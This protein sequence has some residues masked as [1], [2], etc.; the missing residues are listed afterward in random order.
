MSFLFKLVCALAVTTLPLLAQQFV[1]QGSLPGPIVWSEAVEVIDANG[2]GQL[3]VI[4][5]NGQGFSSAQGSRAPTLLINQGG[6][7][8]SIVFA[9]ETSSRIPAGFV[10]QGKGLAI[11]DVNGDGAPDVVFAN[12]FVTQPRVLVNDGTGNFADETTT[13]FPSV[14]LGAFGVA[15]IDADNDGDIDLVFTDG[16]SYFLASPGRPP[17]LFINDG[18]GVFTDS[19]AR[20]NGV[21]KIG[22]MQASAID[23]DNDL[24]LDVIIDGRS[25]G[26]HLY[27]NDGTGTFTFAGAS[28]LPVGGGCIYETDWADLDNDGDADGFYISMSGFSEGTAR[29]NLGPG[30]TGPTLTFTGTTNTISGVNGNDD[31]EAA[32]IDANNDGFLDVLVA[33]LSGSREKLYLNQ[34]TFANGSFVYQSS[35]F[36]TLTDSTLDLAIGDFDQDGRYDVVTAQGESGNYTNRLY[37]NT[38]PAD[39]RAPT[40]VRVEGLPPMLGVAELAAGSR[41][42]Q[43]VDGTADSGRTLVSVEANV[44]ITRDGQTASVILPVAYSGGYLWRFSAPAGLNASQFV[45]AD[46]TM[47]FVAADPPGNIASTAPS[48]TR[49]C[50]VNPYGVA[51]ATNNMSISVGAPPTVGQTTTLMSTGGPANQPAFVVSGPSRASLPIAGGVVLVDPA[52]WT[53]TPLTSDATGTVSFPITVPNNP[54][55]AGAFA[56]YQVAVVDPSQPMGW[57]A[58]TGLE[59]AT[60]PF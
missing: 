42:M 57:S 60:C 1:Y 5:T 41:R 8:G 18:T 52:T 20:M 2:D 13:R 6:A 49:I 51:S 35:G 53:V 37:R 33:S 26:Q 54:A 14:G 39:S 31:N 9:D 50:G 10:Q 19:P 55:N 34:G 25:P 40:F 44:S 46:I 28:V 36:T 11:C 4:F 29:N 32:F 47:V 56:R 27:L 59:M 12:G 7:A 24:D 23:I 22:A 30:Q 16:P 43:V 15:P 48:T 45:G 3:D 17:R 58:S 38:G 21:N